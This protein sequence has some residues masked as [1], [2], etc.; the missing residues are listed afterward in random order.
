MA[1]MADKNAAD[2]ARSRLAAIV[3]SSSDAIVSKTLDGIVT[4]WNRAA[5]RIFG[6]T[7]EEMIG[8][9][10]RVLIPEDRQREEDMFL[11][12]LRQGERISNF[13]TIRRRKNGDLIRVAITVS[14]ILNGAGE[15]VGASKIAR[16]VTVQHE[17]AEQL[18][19]S[20]A[21]FH[22]LA[23]NMNQLAWMARPDGWIFWYNKRWYDFTGT[24]LEDMQGWGWRGVHHP[25]HVDRVVARISECFRTGTPWEDLFPLRSADGDFR[26]FLSR[27]E[28]IRDED[29]RILRWFGTNTDITEQKKDEERIRTL[30][31]EVN[32]RAKNLLAVVQAV[33]R[34]TAS[35]SP[36]DFISRFEA[37]LQALAASQDLLV[38][39]RWGSFDLGELVRSQLAH[40][41]AVGR[42]QVIV[43]GCP[44]EISATAAQPLGMVIHELATNS[45]KYGALSREEGRVDLHWTR[46]GDRL[47]IK[48]R[49]S[50]G[51]PVSPPRQRGY[52]STV[53]ADLPRGMLQGQTETK[54]ARSGLVWRAELPLDSLRPAIPAEEEAHIGGT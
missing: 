21:R 5:E 48:W 16:D 37:R 26:W 19:E 17:T 28:P 3:E 15:I 47:T 18:E 41:P 20:Q 51:P 25:D 7:A 50:G 53:M 36:E 40:L 4:S 29:G 35:C 42:N 54:Y 38:S 10:V 39:G 22:T 33:A 27:A 24:T 44:C 9:S 23:D 49:E 1:T 45:V 13:H 14:P 12:Q 43:E 6:Y 30:L 31:E 52:G 34:R 46:H 2:I 11:A 32:H 8:T